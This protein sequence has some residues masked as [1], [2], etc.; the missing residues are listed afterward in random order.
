MILENFTLNSFSTSNLVDNRTFRYLAPALKLHG[1]IFTKKIVQDVHKLAYGIYDTA[2][3][4]STLIEESNLRPIFILLSVKI[5]PYDLEKFLDYIKFEPYYIA[6]YLFDTD[7]EDPKMRML[8]LDMP[9]EA[10]TAYDN[11]KLG[12]YGDMYTPEQLEFL[13]NDPV[14]KQHPTYKVLTRD[15]SYRE[16]FQKEIEERFETDRKVTKFLEYDFPYTLDQKA[17]I[18]NPN[19]L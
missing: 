18:F 5:R 17:E 8:V 14:R 15:I 16:V 3:A 7:L 4:G 9:K 13:F 11:F 19:Y 10:Y 6:D 1:E 12:A 2:F